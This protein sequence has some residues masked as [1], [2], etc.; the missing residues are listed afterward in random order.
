MDNTIR[1]DVQE[2]DDQ[3][4]GDDDNAQARGIIS[5]KSVDVRLYSSYFPNPTTM[6]V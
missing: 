3:M 6:M 1:L 4:D 5:G 2:N